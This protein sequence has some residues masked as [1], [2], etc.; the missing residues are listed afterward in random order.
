L[1]ATPLSRHRRGETA[2]ITDLEKLRVLLPHW[3]EH[4]AEHA[5]E[6]RQWAERAGEA[7]ADIRAAAEALEQANRALT[8]AQ[9]KLG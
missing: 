1:I 9:E 6:F 7:G 3:I 5:A 4:N 8:A 2:A